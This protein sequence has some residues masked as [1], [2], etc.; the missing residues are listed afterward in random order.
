MF[1]ILP[2]LPIDKFQ[3]DVDELI[4]FFDILDNLRRGFDSSNCGNS[5]NSETEN[6]NE[7]SF[8]PVAQRGVFVSSE[9][10]LGHLR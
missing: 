6:P 5:V 3:V 2:L 7:V 9:L 1:G 8:F 10:A 4:Q